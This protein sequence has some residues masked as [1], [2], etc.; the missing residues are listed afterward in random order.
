MIQIMMRNIAREWIVQTGHF[1]TIQIYI[2]AYT[3]MIR[4]IDVLGDTAHAPQPST[5]PSTGHPKGQ[6]WS[7]LGKKS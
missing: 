3:H 6:T 4:E 5:N 7:P 2:Y 1:V